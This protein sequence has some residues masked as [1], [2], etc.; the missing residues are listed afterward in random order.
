MGLNFGETNVDIKVDKG[1]LTLVP[2]T[3]TVNNG[4]I[5]FGG[6]ADF[7]KKPTMF[8]T[9]GPMRIVKDIQLNVEI[10]NKL[11]AKI[12][13]IFSGTSSITG[14]ADFDCNSLA[15]PIS[16][17][18]QEDIEIAGTVSLT[19]VKMSPTG[20]MGAI[21]AASGASAGDLMMVHP[22][23]FTVKD[24]FVRYTNMQMDIGPLPFNF[25]GSVP[26]NPDREIEDLRITLPIS[27]T[28]KI[29]RVGRDTEAQRM[30]AYIKGTPKNPKL[31]IGKTVIE[32][33][34]QQ[35]LQIFLESQKKK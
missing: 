5:N 34:L 26:L 24:G 7:K 28:G 23:P 21:V 10:T 27:A 11:L 32:T 8:R 12:N 22:T 30:S 13:P 1:Y 33:G 15:V 14:L 4:Q 16:G 25:G 29:V 20:L 19:N 35:G 2:F 3:T 31:D 6:T 9:P 18:R 17:G